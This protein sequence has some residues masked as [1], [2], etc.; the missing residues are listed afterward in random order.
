[1]IKSQHG[2]QWLVHPRPR[3]TRGANHQHVREIQAVESLFGVKRV[4]RLLLTLASHRPQST[5]VE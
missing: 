5:A 3:A 2:E 1:M 4:I